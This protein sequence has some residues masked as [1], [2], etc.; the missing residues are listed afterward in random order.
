MTTIALLD[1]NNLAFR[2]YHAAKHRLTS[3]QGIETGSVHLFFTSLSRY[4][5]EIRPTHFVACWDGGH[6]EYRESIYP[7]Y[8]G[9]RRAANPV[10]GENHPSETFKLIS[11]CL[12]LVGLAQW[13]HEGIE[14]DDLIAAAVKQS[15]LDPDQG[16]IVIMSSD[17]DLLQLLRPGVTQLRFTSD[18]GEMW[19]REKVITQFG[20]TPEQIPSV[21]AFTGDAIDGV[22][23]AKG[24]GPKKAV[25]LLEAHDWNFVNAMNSRADSAIILTSRLLVD[26]D[27]LADK[28]PV[29]VVPSYDPLT[30]LSDNALERLEAFTDFCAQYQL[31]VLWERLVNMTLW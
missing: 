18:G 3:D 10:S 24:I 9:A 8:K 20:Y 14:A 5:Q 7:E 6:S 28:I 11:E 16:N 21:M 15:F 19:D 4:L 27:V 2:C 1:A 29:P 30:P 22:P 13:R 17:K 23:G 25:K 31:K 12:D 26:L